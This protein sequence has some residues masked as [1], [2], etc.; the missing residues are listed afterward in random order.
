MTHN[1]AA[2]TVTLYQNL[3]VIVK[4][5]EIHMHGGADEMCAGRLELSWFAICQ[6][7]PLRQE[8]TPL[9]VLCWLR[10]ISAANVSYLQHVY[11]IFYYR[12]F[13]LCLCAFQ[14]WH[15]RN[16]ADFRHQYITVSKASFI[17]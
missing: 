3:A 2:G 10:Y 4:I 11:R 9:T 6:L 16:F 15:R 8:S 17:V 7:H 5:H 13:S 1:S 12:Q 14:L